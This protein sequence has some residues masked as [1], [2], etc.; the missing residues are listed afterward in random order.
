[1]IF[2]EK[3]ENAKIKDKLMSTS[4]EYDALFLQA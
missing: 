4:H 1:M 3:V 2:K